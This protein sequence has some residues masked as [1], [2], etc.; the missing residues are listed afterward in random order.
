M[1]SDFNKILLLAGNFFPLSVAPAHRTDFTAEEQKKYERIRTIVVEV[2]E[3]VGIAY[4]ERVNFRITKNFS[5][6]ACMV[7][8]VVSFSGPVIDRKSVV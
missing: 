7:G 6:N 1:I 8:N 3:K 2:G 5:Q 4:P